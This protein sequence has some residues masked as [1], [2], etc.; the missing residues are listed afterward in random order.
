MECQGR[1]MREATMPRGVFATNST[2][3]QMITQDLVIMGLE[4]IKKNSTNKVD[5]AIIDDAIELIKRGGEVERDVKRYFETRN[6][7]KTIL[8][9]VKDITEFWELEE[10]L[11][12]VGNED[13]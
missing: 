7:L 10:R 5:I 6:K 9:S 2:H 13:V 1:I 3:P 12:K 8:P 11:E 4:V